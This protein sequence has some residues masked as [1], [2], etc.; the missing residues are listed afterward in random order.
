MEQFTNYLHGKVQSYTV[1][2]NIIE[3]S[4]TNHFLNLKT[5]F[6]EIFQANLAFTGLFNKKQMSIF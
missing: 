5:K 2:R 4:N 3:M 1:L 6:K